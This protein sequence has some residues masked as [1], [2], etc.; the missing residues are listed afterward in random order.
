MLAPDTVLVKSCAPSAGLCVRL[1]VC[2]SACV[3]ACVQWGKV[4]AS[5]SMGGDEEL[6]P[7][8][9]SDLREIGYIM[10]PLLPSPPWSANLAHTQFVALTVKS[11]TTCFST[12]W[13][14]G[15]TTPAGFEILLC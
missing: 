10:S 7:S 3:C 9:R 6:S 15:V 12:S 1:H 4:K 5:Q 2:V 11:R 14:L 13:A 8:S